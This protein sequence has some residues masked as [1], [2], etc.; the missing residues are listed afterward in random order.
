MKNSNL[1]NILILVGLALVVA[2]TQWREDNP[3]SRQQ[4]D[5]ILALSWQPAFCET[6]PNVPEC[7]SQRE[8]RFDARNFSLH[9]L[10]PQP[11]DNV[12]CGVSEQ[13]IR[14]DKSGRWQDLPKLEISDGLRKELAEQ[15]PGYRSNLHRH[16]WIK[17]GTCIEDG[18][19]EQYYTIS[20]QLMGAMN[21]SP[22]AKLFAENIGRE[23]SAYQITNAFER[24]F[25][26]GLGNRI[27]VSCRRDGGRN[28]INELKISLA[29]DGKKKE[30]LSEIF[31]AAAP[32][33]VGCRRGI[34]DPVG[35]Q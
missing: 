19:P 21:A 23:I 5:F 3:A 16:E 10:W 22:M 4:Q 12:Y 25:G 2:Y 28:L 31:E 8:G 20:L 24:T 30:S 1:R 17:H 11:R 32:L 34:V 18:T 7:R 27:S 13:N 9:G 14:I 26:S 29:T 33:D 6:R 15:M 35:L